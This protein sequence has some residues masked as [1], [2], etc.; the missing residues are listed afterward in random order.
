MG[1]GAGS[2][3]RP[4]NDARESRASRDRRKGT[5]G[6]APFDTRITRRS[7]TTPSAN[8]APSVMQDVEINSTRGLPTDR[9][10]YLKKVRAGSRSS[11]TDGAYSDIQKQ[12]KLARTV[13]GV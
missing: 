12:K 8:S 7:G 13:C 5:R 10:L 9:S 6:V 1:G 3:W 4:P 11:R 2:A